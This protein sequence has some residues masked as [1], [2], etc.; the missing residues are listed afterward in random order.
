MSD[1]ARARARHR[2]CACVFLVNTLNKSALYKELVSLCLFPLVTE[3]SSQYLSRSLPSFPCCGFWNPPPVNGCFPSTAPMS[4]IQIHNTL[5]Q[6][7]H[8][9]IRH[10]YSIYCIHK[11]WEL[12]YRVPEL[13]ITSLVPR[14]F[15]RSFEFK[16]RFYIRS[17][18]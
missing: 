12:T 3:Y 5:H 6:R 8:V 10:P 17:R 11:D 1:H 2:L 4:A 7:T 16:A 9:P 13:E 18:D 14:L 15:N